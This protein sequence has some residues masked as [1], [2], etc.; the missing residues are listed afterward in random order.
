[1][2]EDL[3]GLQLPDG[4]QIMHPLGAGAMGEVWV[5][6]SP[7]EGEVAV[8]FLSEKM[9][10][11]EAAVHRFEREWHMASAIDSPH[12]VRMLSR[13]RTHDGR[14]FFA[15]EFLRGESLE[16]RLEREDRL[17][18]DEALAIFRAVA[19]ALDVAHAAGIVH[20]D[21]KPENIL[22]CDGGNP[23]VKLLDFGLA[24]PFSTEGFSLT[25]TG[26]L[27]GTPL[28][29]APEQMKG[30]GRDFDGRADQWALAAVAYRALLGV[31]PFDADSLHA[32][33]LEVM[34]GAY[35]P[36]ATA[37]GD[38]ALEPFFARAF[39]VDREARFPSATVMIE[40]LAEA[41][42]EE[43]SDAP[44]VLDDDDATA[45]DDGDPADEADPEDDGAPTRQYD[46][47]G[48]LGAVTRGGEAR[49]SEDTTTTDVRSLPAAPRTR[50]ASAPP[51]ERRATGAS[52]WL[53]IIVGANVLALGV[54][55]AFMATRAE[56]DQRTGA[57]PRPSAPVVVGGPTTED[58]ASSADEDDAGP[59]PDAPPEG[60]AVA[61][62]GVVPS[63]TASTA[64]AGDD[65]SDGAPP[66]GEPASSPEIAELT[67]TCEPVCIVIV[68]GRSR[69]LSPLTKTR[70]APGVHTILAYRDD[71]GTKA[72]AL[73]LPRGRHVTHRVD[74]RRR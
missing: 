19:D 66:P 47:E 4:T 27:M 61:P 6:V 31:Q 5:G 53:P 46:V 62:P 38:P 18:A 36:V 26:V 23:G 20:R 44:T 56:G 28:Y 3:A 35:R 70:I 69:G 60:A 58:V 55:A 10:Y 48:M 42:D 51:P 15:M 29:M 50:G 74:L 63:A 11:D 32:L 59:Y 72:V 33:V 54:L 21:I 22:L 43:I 14:P 67:V 37:G 71:L 39:A 2:N 73:E 17:D 25:K 24:K 65:A 9:R 52:R 7:D 12:V 30:G 13:G 57:L 34:R 8:K 45:F 40:A 41:L 1:M 64:A 68:D 16:T 49:S